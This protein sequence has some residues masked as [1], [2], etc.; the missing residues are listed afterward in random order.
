[1]KVI[2]MQ[3]VKKLGNKGDVVNASDGYARNY[4]FPRKLA[5][6]ATQ[7]NLQNLEIMKERQNKQKELEKA[8]A[9]ADGDKLGKSPL[10]ITAKAGAKG[11]LFGSITTMEIVSVIEEQVGIKIDKRK[12]ELPEP[13]KNLGEYKV[14]IKLHPEVHGEINIMVKAAE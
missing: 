6:E 2:L 1:M 5:I 9:K 11:R 10:V 3:D 7:Q 12:I 13:I 14:K 8:K 4:L